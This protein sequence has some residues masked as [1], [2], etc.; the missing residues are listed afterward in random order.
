MVDAKGGP[1]GVIAVVQRGRQRQVLTAGVSKLGSDRP[2][3]ASMHMRLASTSK[4][5]SGAI[6]L[7]LVESGELNLDDTVGEILPS[8]AP[9]WNDVTLQQALTHTSGIPSFTTNAEFLDALSADPLVGPPDQASLLSYVTDEPLV[10]PPDSSYAY[11]NSD[12]I[13]VAL[14]AEEATGLSYRQVLRREVLRPLG[15]RKTSLP[16]TAKM[17]KPFIH[18]YDTPGAQ[19]DPEDYSEVLDPNWTGASGGLVSTPARPQR[20]RARLHQRR[21]VRQGGPQAAARRWS[22]GARS[23][24][25]RAGTAPAPASSATAA[26][27]APSSATPATS[28]ATRSSSA[29]PRTA[30]A[31]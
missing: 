29:P 19:G 4:A 25:A 6:A 30:G 13:V 3:R 5:F 16:P 9:E 31:R 12:N 26:T 2:P 1:P 27:A 10:F 15:M 7:S 8:L 22:R 23:R 18:G 14:M 28:S 20:L 17:P 11:S 21:A 24:P